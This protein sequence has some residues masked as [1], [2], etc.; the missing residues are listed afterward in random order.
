MLLL[1]ISQ[2][3][4]ALRNGRLDEAYAIVRQPDVR[5]HRRGQELLEKLVR[6]LIDRGRQHLAAGRLAEASA[7]SEKAG[8]LAGNVETVAQLQAAVQ[9]ALGQEQEENR[10]RGQALAIARRQMDRGELSVVGRMLETVA[11][12]EDGRVDGLKRELHARQ[13]E[14]QSCERKASVALAAADWEA[15]ID[16]LSPLPVN[17]SQ[18]G[19]LRRLCGQI[20]QDVA[21][22]IRQSIETGR[23]DTAAALAAKLHK[24]PIET[25]EMTEVNSLL[26]QCSRARDAIESSQWRDAEEFL[27]RI[28]T[29]LPQ[30]KWVGQELAQVK[31]LGEGM[32][33]LRSGPLSLIGSNGVPRMQEPVMFD[34]FCL[35][36]DGAG[37]FKVFTRPS[38]TLGP[39]SSSRSVDVPLA[40]DSGTKPITVSRAEDDYFVRG[41][42][43][44]NRL[45]TNG[46][47]F[48]VGSRGRIMFRRP[49]AASATAVL[50]LAEARPAGGN[51]RN[52]VMMDR[53]IVIGPGLGDHIR[54]ADLSQSAILQRRGNG[55]VVRWNGQTISVTNSS[56]ITLGTLHLAVTREQRT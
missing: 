25:T 51:L 8:H 37:S 17:S 4:R 29:L 39:I 30:A 54:A 55:V 48:A 21:Q 34:E 31:Q 11:P 1:Q 35:H 24:L 23:L 15:A 13:L 14:I 32:S 49:S 53:E 42:D 16:H 41:G 26:N 12:P 9:H 36:V 45:L 27:G 22:R 20:G 52:I 46:E 7:D 47:K 5:S 40:I 3:E 56:P 44:A 33:Q 43:G 10:R 50:D 19:E 38:I 18:N 6:A 28:Q 2:C